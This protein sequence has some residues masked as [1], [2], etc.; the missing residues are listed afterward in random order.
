VLC[1]MFVAKALISVAKCVVKGKYCAGVVLG[2]SITSPFE[3]ES[4]TTFY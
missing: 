3:T 2:S 1:A 4:S